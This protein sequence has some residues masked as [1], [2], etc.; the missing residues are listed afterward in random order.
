MW[1]SFPQ[2]S[3]VTMCAGLP[4]PLEYEISSRPVLPLL[5]RP[6]V[7]GYVC[8]SVL[9]LFRAYMQS[10]CVHAGERCNP[11]IAQGST[12]RAFIKVHSV[13]GTAASLLFFVLP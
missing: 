1:I 5:L 9:P 4:G 11:A 3:N 12:V 13:W 10:F 6:L 7:R 2:G 8:W